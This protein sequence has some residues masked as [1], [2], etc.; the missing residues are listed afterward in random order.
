MNTELKQYAET[1]SWKYQ[2]DNSKALDGWNNYSG[3]IAYPD[4]IVSVGQ[5]RDSDIMEVSNFVSALERL[6]GESKHVKIERFGHWGCGW[7]ELILVNPKSPKHVKIAFEISKDLEN[8]PLLDESDYYERENEYQAEYAES[9]KTDLAEAISKHFG[10]K[11]GKALTNLCFD[12]N[13]ECQRY[14]GNDSCV[15]VYASRMPD[16]RDIEVL[17]TCLKQLEYQ[18]K[19]SRVFKALVQKLN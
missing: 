9:A 17:K 1:H 10:L 16:A 14:Y 18:Y 15:N 4:W 3:G 6:G 5:N 11:N 2:M 8:Y 12:L 7:F 13:L 19:N